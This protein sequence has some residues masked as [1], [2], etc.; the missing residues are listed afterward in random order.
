MQKIALAVLVV[1]FTGCDVLVDRQK[2]A[3]ERKQLEAQNHFVRGQLEMLNV[4]APACVQ[5][6]MEASA[7]AQQKEPLAAKK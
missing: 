6:L 3:D 5:K 4:I 1:F 7:S 2:I